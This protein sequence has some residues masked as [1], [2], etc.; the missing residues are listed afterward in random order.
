[1][2]C[3]M[4]QATPTLLTSSDNFL[5]KFSDIISLRSSR[6]VKD[7]FHTHSKPSA[8]RVC[9]VLWSLEYWIGDEKTKS[10]G[11]NGSNILLRIG[12]FRE[13]GLGLLLQFRKI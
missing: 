9:C 6:L 7:R 5:G 2:C 1:M 3:S 11:M 8:K 4:L 13:R 10:L 12:I